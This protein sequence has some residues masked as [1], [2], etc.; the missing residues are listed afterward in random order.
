MKRTQKYPTTSKMGPH[1]PALSSLAKHFFLKRVSKVVQTSAKIFSHEKVRNKISKF[2][3]YKQISVLINFEFVFF[4]FKG[5]YTFVLGCIMKCPSIV[6]VRTES[7]LCNL[8]SDTIINV[9]TF[10]R[11]Q[12]PTAFLWHIS[13]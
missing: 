11:T 7:P 1:F 10:F 5:A 12:F 13:L 4:L 8:S 3:K 6:C 2:Q 9:L